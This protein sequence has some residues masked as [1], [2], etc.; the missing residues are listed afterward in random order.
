[1]IVVP[2]PSPSMKPITTMHSVMVA[3]VAYSNTSYHTQADTEKDRRD[4]RRRMSRV[5]GE[6]R[7]WPI[8]GLQ[9]LRPE[10]GIDLWCLGLHYI[11]S[12]GDELL[13]LMRLCVD[14]SY[15]ASLPW[16]HQR[17]P[18]QHRA[19]TP[20]TQSSHYTYSHIPQ[21]KTPRHAFTPYNITQH[22]YPL[23]CTYPDAA[24]GTRRA[25][26]GTT[27]WPMGPGTGTPAIATPPPGCSPGPH[28][29]SCST[30]HSS[31]RPEGRDRQANVSGY[32]DSSLYPNL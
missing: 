15:H 12:D 1:M 5:I 13:S 29:P 10:N 28:P 3:M 26:V 9:D 27:R 4:R 11:V 2:M 24:A 18:Q 31:S 32:I 23:P 17:L 6:N 14:V 20:S 22:L 19:Y 8:V 7:L 25:A 21:H 30:A 16:L